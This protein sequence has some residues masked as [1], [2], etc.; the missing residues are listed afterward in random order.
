MANVSGWSGRAYG[1]WG[2]IAAYTSAEYGWNDTQGW[3]RINNGGA[4]ETESY[5]YGVASHHQINNAG[6]A[7]QCYVKRTGYLTYNPGGSEAW[8]TASASTNWVYV[9][10]TTS[11][12]TFYVYAKANGETVSGYGAYGADTGWAHVATFVIPKLPVYAPNAPTNASVVRSSDTYAT[13]SW[14]NNTDVT[15]PYSGLYVERKTDDGSFVQVATVSSGSTSWVDT[16][17]TANHYY[18]YRVRAYNSSGNSSYAT[19]GTIYNTPAAPTDVSAAVASGTTVNVTWKTS[20]NTASLQRIQY[21]VKTGSS[22]GEWLEL[23]TVNAGI[24]FY[25]HTGAPGGTVQYRIRSE[26]G[27]L[28]SDFASSNETVTIQP[29]AAPTLISLPSANIAVGTSTVR[30]SWRHNSLDT[31]IQ[32]AAQIQISLNGGTSWFTYTVSG[33]QAYYD[34]NTS[35][36]TDGQTITFRVR[37]KGADASYGPYSTTVSFTM[38]A[39]PSVSITSPANDSVVI[40]QLPFSIVWTFSNGSYSLASYRMNIYDSKG[41][42]V[43]QKTGTEVESFEMNP[44]SFA[45]NNN[46]SYSIEV[47]VVAETGIGASATRKFSVDYEVPAKPGIEGQFNLS[48][49]SSSLNVFAGQE[50]GKPETEYMQVFRIMTDYDFASTSLNLINV[51]GE[52]EFDGATAFYIPIESNSSSIL[53][54]SVED[55]IGGTGDFT[56]EVLDAEGNVEASSVLNSNKKGVFLDLGGSSS[57]SSSSSSERVLALYPGVKDGTLQEGVVFVKPMLAS[58]IGTYYGEGTESSYSFPAYNDNILNVSGIDVLIVDGISGSN[59]VNVTD[60]T[61]QL[62][63]IVLYK[64]VAVSNIGTSAVAYVLVNISSGRRYAL[65]WGINMSSVAIMYCGA[66]YDESPER[67]GEVFYPAGREYGVSFDGEIFEEPIGL[68][69]YLIDENGVDDEKTYRLL[70]DCQKS[71]T[72]KVLRL[73]NGSVFYINTPAFKFKYDGKNDFRTASLDAEVVSG[74]TSTVYQWLR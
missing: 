51:P 57:S 55:I 41:T 73:P 38:R 43:F 45:P 52:I 13:I 59:V 2:Y 17:I 37:T 23:A 44:Q 64:V 6:G 74:N 25:T 58:F 39:V 33:N 1:R 18:S 31:S 71:N 32:T 24:T 12:Q 7:A 16:G 50:E 27:D 9:N 48:S 67:D 5:L 3:F 46:S 28:V 66:K 65:N 21:R 14:I 70:R 60:Y 15:H 40:D 68:S 22:W 34:Y 26:R 62:N 49:L 47:F 36:L 56:V 4:V 42:S 30:I 63:E 11:D 61:P 54:F 29:P 20:A 19:T 69:F 8:V 10:R 35:A 72:D 53:T